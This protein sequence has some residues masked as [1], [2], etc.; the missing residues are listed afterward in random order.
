MGK[1]PDMISHSQFSLFAV[2]LLK[3]VDVNQNS[4]VMVVST[5]TGDFYQILHF[6]ELLETT[7]TMH[8][9]F[10]QGQLK[11]GIPSHVDV[12]C[13]RRLLHQTIL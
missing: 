10:V 6:N 13:H 5:R 3:M 4:P 9:N 7:L 12:L 11:L 1:Q 2:S 8:P